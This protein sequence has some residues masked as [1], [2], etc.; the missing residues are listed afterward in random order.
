MENTEY[1]NQ[2][3]VQSCNPK[4]LKTNE[5]YDIKSAQ[6]LDFIY[7]QSGTITIKYT[8]TNSTQPYSEDMIA[9]KLIDIAY[10]KN[11]EGITKYIQR[12]SAKEES[13]IITIP[14]MTYFSIIDVYLYIG[15][16]LL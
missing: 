16:Q 11:D 7:I 5:H 3:L 12:I 15:L 1:K 13:E 9:G 4:R 14:Y 2:Q 8:T 10:W 6:E